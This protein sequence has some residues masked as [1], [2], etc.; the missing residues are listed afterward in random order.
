MNGQSIPMESTTARR[1]RA[2]V[3]L[4]VS[5]KEQAERGGEAEG[6][7]IPA[8]RE[9]CHR[10]AAALEA[11]VLDE[12]VDRGESAKTSN[13]PELQRLLVYVMEQRVDYVIVHKVD[14]LA[15]NRLDD[16]L[17]N[18]ELRKAGA[19][20]VSCTENID[21]TPSGMLMHGIMSS[22]SEFYSRNL[23]AEVL[24]GS[25]KK[26]QAGGLPGRAPTGYVNVRRWENGTEIRTVEVDPERGPLMAWV[27]ET[28]ASGDTSVRAV[29]SEA[30]A[31]GLTSQPSAKRA[32]KPLSL[33]NMCVLLRSPFYKGVVVYRGVEYPGR[34][35]PLVSVETWN[36]VQETLTAQNQQGE[37]TRE[38]PHYL[39]GTV[40][41]GQC[42]SRLIVSHN[43]NR[44]GTVYPYF[45]CL[46][47]QKK[48]GCT[49]RAMLIDRVQ[50]L[51][52]EH[53][54]SVQVPG[55]LVD[56][57]R[58][59][60]LEEIGTV[61]AQAAKERDSQTRLMGRLQDERQKLLDGYYAGAIPLDLLK[62]EQ[63]RIQSR[64]EAA[65]SAVARSSARFEAVT[66]NLSSA[67]AMAGNWHRAYLAASDKERRLLNRAI[68]EKMYVTYEGEVTHDFAEPFRALLSQPVLSHVVS[69]SEADELTPEV[70]MAIDRAWADLSAR[71]TQ[72]E[73]ARSARE[74]LRALSVPTW[75]EE[76]RTPD[77]L[78]VVGGSN[79]CWMVDREGLEPPTP[80]L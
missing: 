34:H 8:Q 37:K 19:T 67:L 33:S 40:W 36:K 16:A 6:F 47:R 21:E 69:R 13:R 51:V 63:T 17:I 58:T 38:H 4:R 59:V 68:F 25:T 60:L 32:G 70:S 74:A 64:L 22:I 55:E 52:E 15:R 53:Y 3:Y 78:A 10:K 62:S 31:R 1:A 5:T 9:A 73:T 42:G 44:H 29:L 24:K 79:A 35:E 12:F 61:E 66:A 14:R 50:E 54:Q 77:N 75:A 18:M 76:D 71:W 39:K 28:Y 49:Q 72:E 41:C 45:I 11:D 20:L 23:A 46:G 26:A 30:T 80:A 2:V 65:E 56:R 48:N 43:K 7:S 57:I 27:F